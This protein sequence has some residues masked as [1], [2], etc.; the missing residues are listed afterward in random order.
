MPGTSP[1]PP[2]IPAYDWQLCFLA[3]REP[4]SP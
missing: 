3:K 1:P 4:A 2:P